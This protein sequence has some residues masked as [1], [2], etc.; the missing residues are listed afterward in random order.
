MFIL[1]QCIFSSSFTNS[2]NRAQQIACTMTS[3][4]A[5][6]M[7]R[8]FA[9]R[10][11]NQTYLTSTPMLFK[12]VS[13]FWKKENKENKGSE[14]KNIFGTTRP[15]IHNLFQLRS[16]CLGIHWRLLTSN[17]QQKCMKKCFLLCKSI[18]IFWK[19]ILLNTPDIEI[20]PKCQKKFLLD[21][22]LQ[23]CTPF[24]FASS[25]SSWFYFVI[26]NS[27]MNWCT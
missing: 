5:T 1:L 3:I 22:M 17:K 12:V 21:K 7:Q 24:H 26:C 10:Q 25:N 16:F 2:M 23:K 19:I 6:C 11:I 4:H 18:Y 8:G 13:Y 9:W 15:D 14:K 20:K 27:Y